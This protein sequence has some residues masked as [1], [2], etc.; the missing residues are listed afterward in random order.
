MVTEQGLREAFAARSL[1]RGSEQ[2]FAPGA[3][4]AF[5]DAC[6]EHDLAPVGIEG[7]DVRRAEVSPRLDQIADFS[8]LAAEP[9]TVFKEKAL[10]TARTF[11]EKSEGS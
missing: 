10:A 5:M 8:E 11:L 7:F 4:L 6:T 1:V 2:Y 9:W 3:A